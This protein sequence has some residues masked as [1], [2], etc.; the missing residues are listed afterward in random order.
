MTYGAAMILFGLCNVVALWC[1]GYTVY[2]AAPKSVAAWKQ[3]GHLLLTNPAFR[4]I[5]I[6]LAATYGLYV[7]SSI[8]HGEPWHLA[9]SFLRESES[10]SAY[11]AFTNPLLPTEYMF[12][13]PSC[14]LNV[15]LEDISS[16]QSQ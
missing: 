14:K 13:L 3:F 16:D 5:V 12:L 7:F 15:I 4:D 6:S 2:A 1:A 9:S 8:L 10:N 11:A